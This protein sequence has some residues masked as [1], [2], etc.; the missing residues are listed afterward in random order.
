MILNDRRIVDV[1]TLEVK[2][3][4]ISFL[5]ITLVSFSLGFVEKAPNAGVMNDAVRGSPRI[6]PLVFLSVVSNVMT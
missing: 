5:L 2:L 1:S 4:L 6:M 3:I